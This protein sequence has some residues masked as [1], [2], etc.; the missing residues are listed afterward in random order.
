[1]RNVLKLAGGT[2]GSQV[3][4]VAAAPILTRLYGPESFGIL[5]TFA[6]ILALL[7]VVSS[8]RYELAIAVPDD[9]EDAITLVWLCFLMVA[10]STGLTALGVGLLGNNLVSW[11]HQPS[12]KPL[13]WLLPVGVLLTGIYQPLTYW[14]IRNKQFGLLAQAKFSQNF[15]GVA[16]NLVAAPLGTIGLLLGQIVMQSAGLVTILQKSITI[17][18]R[19]PNLFCAGYLKTLKRYSHFAIYSSPA[20]LVNMAGNQ[21]PYLIF[22]SAFGPEDLGQLAIAQRLLLLPAGLIGDSVSQVFLGKASECIRFGTLNRLVKTTGIKLLACGLLISLV[23]SI[24][25]APF[26]TYILGNQWEAVKRIIPLLTPL[27]VGQLT[28]STLSMAFIAAENN[29][30]ELF[31]QVGQASLR[32]G[33]LAGVIIAGQSFESSVL[34]FSGGS[35]LGYLFYGG[36]L[37]VSLMRY[38]PQHL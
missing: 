6:S 33:V 22:A 19:G 28:V 34:V 32:L 38:P 13:L 31:A 36:V 9:D 4:A 11:L 2:A 16:T 30:L 1:V 20:G 18:S 5:A 35:L 8:L 27:L 24:V 14:T 3:I 26:A 7:N 23:M 12:L 37:L 17:F 21:L 25:V 29:R 10:I 15:L